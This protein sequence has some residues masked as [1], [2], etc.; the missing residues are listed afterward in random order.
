MVILEKWQDY[1]YRESDTV[2]RIFSA[3]KANRDEE[4][5]YGGRL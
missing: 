3:R 2:V 1:L 4:N 5:E